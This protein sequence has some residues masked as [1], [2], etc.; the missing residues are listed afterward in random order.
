MQFVYKAIYNSLVDSMSDTRRLGRLHIRCQGITAA[1]PLL[2]MPPSYILAGYH[3]LRDKHNT[4]AK[5][6]GVLCYQRGAK[7]TPSPY[8]DTLVTSPN[9]KTGEKL[10]SKRVKRNFSKRIDKGPLSGV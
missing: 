7:R 6:A 4:P 3:A 9:K 8:L 1:Q 2:S 10:D 5:L